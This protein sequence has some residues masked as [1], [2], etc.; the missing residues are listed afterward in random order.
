MIAR[1]LIL[2]LLFSVPLCFAE[3]KISVKEGGSITAHISSSGLNRI[4]VNGD[5]ILTIKGNA[6]QFQMDKDPKL[7]QIY[8]Q[9]TLVDKGDPIHIFITTE[10]GDTYTL[11][12][13]V[14]DLAPENIVL[15][16][17]VSQAEK[18][19]TTSDYESTLI[20][21]IK[22]MYHQVPLEGYRNQILN[23]KSSPLRGATVMHVQSLIGDKIRGEQY[24]I[25]NKKNQV[26]ILEEKDFYG[27]GVRAIAI[28]NK[29]LLPG[30]TTR[31]YIIKNH[32]G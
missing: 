28:M 30:V 14:H 8:L 32:Y 16:P 10:K 7:G 17:Q 19:K 15:V 26:V 6:G 1:V 12:L 27:N 24:E 21:I 13:L 3:Q 18:L 5:R 22:A 9:P 4:A 31:V 20:D 2:P 29:A 11:S 23:K 25:Y